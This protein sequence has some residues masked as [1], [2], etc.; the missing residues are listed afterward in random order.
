[1]FTPRNGQ[2]IPNILTIFTAYVQISEPTH[3]TE[4]IWFIVYRNLKLYF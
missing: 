2:T 1:M 4:I 3:F